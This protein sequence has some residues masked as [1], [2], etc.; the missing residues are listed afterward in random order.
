MRYLPI[1]KNRSSGLITAYTYAYV[2]NILA[3]LLRL[4]F[5]TRR[6]ILVDLNLE[7]KLLSRLTQSNKQ[8]QIVSKYGLIN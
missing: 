2:L 5:P 8:S 1:F 6:H 7:L 3:H 4:R